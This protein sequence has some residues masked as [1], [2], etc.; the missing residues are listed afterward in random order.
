[1]KQIISLKYNKL[2]LLPK[3]V[4]IPLIIYKYNISD[5]QVCNM[6]HIFDIEVRHSD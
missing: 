3:V 6:K 2:F 1:M 5:Q 4:F